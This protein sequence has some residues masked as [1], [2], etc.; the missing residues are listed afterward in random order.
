MKLSELTIMLIFSS[1]FFYS[2]L[3]SK[4]TPKIRKIMAFEAIGEAVKRATEMGQ[5]VLFTSGQSQAAIG[6]L[7][8]DQAPQIIAGA[9]VCQEAARHTAR[10]NTRLV[11]A[12]TSPDT[13]P[14]FDE[15]LKMTYMAEGHSE[16]YKSNV[17]VRWVA[18]E[19]T[20][21]ESEVCNIILKE[22]IATVIMVGAF[23]AEVVVF[24]ETA[25]DKGAISIFGTTNMANLPIGVAVC[26]YALIASEMFAASAYTTQDR[27]QLLSIAGED[28]NKLLW[29]VITVLGAISA[30]AS[31]SWL[32]NLFKI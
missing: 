15:N 10:L 8:T 23:Y 5:E 28:Y 17:D 3:Y 13:I 1:I 11:V 27:L 2:I 30:A 22:P 19:A 6:G 32:F 18:S 21:Y 29:I 20:S 9:A 31:S 16:E 7:I 4:A 24:A 25:A 12:L 26:D 14:L